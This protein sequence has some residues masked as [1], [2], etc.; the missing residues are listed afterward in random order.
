MKVVTIL[1]F[2]LSYFFRGGGGG[3]CE[4]NLKKNRSVGLLVSVEVHSI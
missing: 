4:T 3:A 2:A 1:V